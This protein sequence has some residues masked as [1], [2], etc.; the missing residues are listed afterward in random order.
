MTWPA[1]R[2]CGEP[3][4]LDELQRL[5]RRRIEERMAELL[6]GYRVPDDVHAG[7]CLRIHDADAARRRIEGSAIP[8][9]HTP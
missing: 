5:K 8:S 6:P 7:K 9:C 2:I 3:V 1:C 4:E